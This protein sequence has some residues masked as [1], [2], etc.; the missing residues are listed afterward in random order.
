MAEQT[1]PRWPATKIFSWAWGLGTFV[2]GRAFKARKVGYRP[3]LYATTS[4][5]AEMK[6][7][8]A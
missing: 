5:V 8:L 2:W 1:M 7:D 4:I 6:M 3:C